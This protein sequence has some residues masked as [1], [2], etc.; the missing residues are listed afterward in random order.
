MV[1]RRK[2]QH[3]LCVKQY[4]ARGPR[5]NLTVEAQIE[6]NLAAIRARHQFTLSEDDCYSQRGDYLAERNKR[7]PDYTG[8]PTDRELHPNHKVFTAA[9][10]AE[11]KRIR[12]LFVNG[13]ETV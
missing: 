8:L 12:R 11:L 5:R 1:H 6:A 13:V 4:V 9:R 3:A 2:T 10:Q 7:M